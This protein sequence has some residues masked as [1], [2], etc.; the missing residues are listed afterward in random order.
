MSELFESETLLDELMFTQDKPAEWVPIE[1]A[2]RDFP[3]S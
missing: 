1:E 3:N 2:D